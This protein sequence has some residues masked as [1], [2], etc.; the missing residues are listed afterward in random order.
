MNVANFTQ[1]ALDGLTSTCVEWS[2]LPLLC[3]LRVVKPDPKAEEGRSADASREPVT[4]GAALALFGAAR[5]GTARPSDSAVAAAMTAN[6][7][8]FIVRSPLRPTPARPSGHHRVADDH[9]G[10]RTG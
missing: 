5:A 4:C 10:G 2:L 3:R 8:N 6:D 9:S 1:L 7:L